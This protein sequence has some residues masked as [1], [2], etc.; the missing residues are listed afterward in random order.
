[1]IKDLSNM[2]LQ[3]EFSGSGDGY[4]VLVETTGLRSGCPE[5]AQVDTD[6]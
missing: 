3:K 6:I 2:C 4:P 5:S 1:M